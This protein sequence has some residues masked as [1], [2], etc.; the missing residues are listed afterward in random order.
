MKKHGMI[1]GWCFLLALSPVAAQETGAPP[2]AEAESPAGLVGLRLEE[3]YATFGVPQKVYAVRGQ[4]PWQDDVVFVYQGVDCYI[5]EEHVW[6]VSVPAAYGVN[7]GDTRTRIQETL[8]E[9]GGTVY[10]FPDSLLFKLPSASWEMM[11]RV[12]F[13]EAGKA[14]AVFIYRSDM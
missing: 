5:F 2:L 6:L 12:N 1:A 14:K 4:E 13:D 9:R 10:E 7:V 3:L 11:M 8:G